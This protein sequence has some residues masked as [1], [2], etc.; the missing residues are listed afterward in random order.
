MTETTPSA[1]PSPGNNP[2]AGILWM[3]LT[4][5]C[6]VAVTAGVKHVGGRVPAIEA[7][8]LRYLFGLVFLIPMWSQ[9]R[10]A[11]LDRP[12]LGLFVVRGLLQ[13]VAVG[14]WFF[15]MT[16]ITM[17]EVTAMNYLQPVLVTLGAALFLGERL[18]IRR[19]MAVV[20]GLLGVLIILRPGLRPLGSGHLAML[21]TSVMFAGSYLIAK[22]LTGRASPAVIVAMMSLVVTLALTPFALS[23]WVTPSTGDLM[24]LFLVAAFA[25]GGHYAMMLSFRAAP[26]AVTQPVTFLQL[27]W[28]VALGAIMFGERVDGWVVLGGGLI[29]G[30]VSFIAVREA[31]LASAARS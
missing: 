10:V 18:A 21:G 2:I 24:A 17:A 4:G 31:R 20:V 13:A 5:L 11:R 12:I 3:V 19:M 26:L 16:R 23:V 6:F 29:M 27:V 28:S 1:I 25:T 7:A 8:F 15:A 14:L 9:L 30:A 22:R